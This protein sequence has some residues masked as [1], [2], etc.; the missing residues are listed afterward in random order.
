[1]VSVIPITKSTTKPEHVLV[2]YPRSGEGSQSTP[3]L[4]RFHHELYSL[5]GVGDGGGVYERGSVSRRVYV[6]RSITFLKVLSQVSADLLLS[7]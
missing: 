6:E 4:F 3:R 2:L 7:F 1:M 5:N